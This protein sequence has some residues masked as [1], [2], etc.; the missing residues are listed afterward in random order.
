MDIDVH[1]KAV[2][3]SSLIDYPGKVAAVVFLN[4]CNY[5]CSFCHNPE[6]VFDEYSKD[7]PDIPVEEFMEFLSH[8]KK[9]IDGVTILG[10]EP[11][12]HKGLLDFMRLLK[13][14]GFDVKLD[15]NGTNPEI[16]KKAISEKIVDYIAMDIKNSRERYEETVK[17]KPSLEKI[18]ESIKLI[19][20]AG[21][22]SLIE[23]DFRTTALPRFHTK[24]DFEKISQWIKGA[25]TYYI[26]QFRTEQSLVDNSLIDDQTFSLSELEDFKKIMEKTIENVTIRE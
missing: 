25:K 14:K 11:T 17:V 15:T 23:Y 8:K 1:I 16:I 7:M 26:Q 18:D 10:G 12:L 19:M 13:S 6:L 5:R 2:V 22:S 21:K 24:D 4:K 9:W 3:K 20:D